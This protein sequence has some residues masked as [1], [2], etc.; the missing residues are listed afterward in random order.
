MLNK[1]IVKLTYDLD[2]YSILEDCDYKGWE[3]FY[4][5]YPTIEEAIKVI[6]SLVGS[7]AKPYDQYTEEYVIVKICEFLDSNS[8]NYDWVLET[9]N[10][11]YAPYD[12]EYLEEFPSVYDAWDHG[13]QEEILD[14]LD[15]RRF[16]PTICELFDFQVGIAK[17][18]CQ[19]DWAVYIA[20][21][22][23]EQEYLNDLLTGDGWLYI[24]VTYPDGDQDAL[25]ACYI[26]DNNDLYDCIKSN[27]GL[28]KEDFYLVDT[29]AIPYKVSHPYMV[30]EIKIINYDYKVI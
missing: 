21:E 22:G 12:I 27:F 30:E 4:Q 3:M 7:G 25:G 13:Y 16:L 24:E 20:T 26:N 9:L 14:I 5:S 10:E 17:G 11:S 28:D 6:T 2:F 23:Y 29:E 19:G 8:N 1:A 15:D 18:Y